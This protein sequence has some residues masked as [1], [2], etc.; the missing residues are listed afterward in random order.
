MPTTAGYS[1][2]PLAK[3]LGIK[4][5][6]RVIALG[7]PDDYAALLA[8][9]PEGVVIVDRLEKDAAFVH[10]FAADRAALDGALGE[11]RDHLVKNG[12]LWLS[13]PKKASG[14][15]TDLDGNAI[16]SAGL[17]G[18]L[19]DVKVCAVDATW[20]GHKFVYRLADR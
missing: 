1:G 5:G 16:R 19:V 4:P 11:A 9:L 17:G 18:G 6:M 3:K 10:L 12:T 13:W 20:S 14:V 2:T 8:P 7:A 15:A